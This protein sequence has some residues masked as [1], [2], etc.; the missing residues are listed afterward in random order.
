[1]FRKVTFAVTADKTKKEHISI[2]GPDRGG[3]RCIAASNFIALEM[4]AVL[5]FQGRADR[6]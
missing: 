1:M 6:W 2:M 5:D 3:S 4:D